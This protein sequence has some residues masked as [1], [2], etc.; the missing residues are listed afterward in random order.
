MIAFTYDVLIRALMQARADGFKAGAA[1]K[2]LKPKNYKAKRCAQN[3]AATQMFVAGHAEGC[4]Y[5]DGLQGLLTPN[6]PQSLFWCA[7]YATY[8]RDQ[9]KE[10]DV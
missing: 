7:G 8:M 6:G 2:P 10:T 3:K 5:H 4:Q 1:G 9:E